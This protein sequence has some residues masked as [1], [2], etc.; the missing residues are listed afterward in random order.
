MEQVGQLIR[1]VIKDEKTE[2]SMEMLDW[3]SIDRVMNFLIGTM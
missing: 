1:D 3:P 2:C